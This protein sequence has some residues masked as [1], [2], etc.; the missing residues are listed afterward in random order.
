MFL[1]GKYMFPVEKLVFQG[2]KH[3]FPVRKHKN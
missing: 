1:D 3:K 2:E